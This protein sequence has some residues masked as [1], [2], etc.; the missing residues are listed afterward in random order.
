MQKVL[1]LD[2]EEP[3][4]R[5]LN[6]L[7]RTEYDVTQFHDPVKAIE[8]FEQNHY[9]LIL[10]DIR[11]P[12]IDGFEVMAKFA[13]RFPDSGRIL[14]SGY[15][16]LDECQDAVKRGV[17]HIIVSK[18][19]DNFELTSIVKLLIENCAMKKELNKLKAD[20]IAK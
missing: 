19:W 6:R 15:A 10:S 18:P 3:V 8:S 2:D 7:F 20:L 17:A 13:E 4:L 9:D 14:I 5:A 16:D 1:I 11:M 12:N